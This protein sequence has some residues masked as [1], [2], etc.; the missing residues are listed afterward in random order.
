MRVAIAQEAAT[1]GQERIAHP[2]GRG[3]HV[4]R[5]LLPCYGRSRG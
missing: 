1:Q 3:I 4:G 2:P 5:R